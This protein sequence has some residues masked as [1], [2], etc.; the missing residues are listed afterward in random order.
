M[1]T[2]KPLPPLPLD[3]QRH[4]KKRG[5]RDKAQAKYPSSSILPAS[6]LANPSIPALLNEADQPPSA[7]PIGLSRKGG[8]KYAPSHPNP[9]TSTIEPPLDHEPVSSLSSH[10]PTSTPRISSTFQGGNRS[11][12]PHL[13]PAASRALAPSRHRLG[14]SDSSRQTPVAQSST[15]LQGVN[16][17]ALPVSNLVTPKAFTPRTYS[18]ALD[19]PIYRRPSAALTTSRSQ[20]TTESVLRPSLS[21]ICDLS[22][23][24]NWSTAVY[25]L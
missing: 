3:L 23:P 9:T 4:S 24:S 20:G 2:G 7:L 12:P 16:V 11:I 1:D 15:V 14:P 6:G 19:N 25:A 22:R 17:S 8:K 10:Q 21:D 13:H 5:K 18:S